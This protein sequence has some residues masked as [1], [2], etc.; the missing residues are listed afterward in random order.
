MWSLYLSAQPV[1]G[2]ECACWCGKDQGGLLLDVT[3]EYIPPPL[4]PG[5]DKG[6]PPPTNTDGMPLTFKQEDFLVD[7][8]FQ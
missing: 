1:I 2:A 4:T 6:V 3:K 5:Q 7:F 8:L